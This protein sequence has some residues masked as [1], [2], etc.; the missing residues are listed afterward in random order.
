MRS[1]VSVTFRG[2]FSR[3]LKLKNLLTER[4]WSWCMSER[5]FEIEQMKVGGWINKQKDVKC[6][7]GHKEEENIINE[8]H[9]LFSKVI[10]CLH[11]L[12][13]RSITY[14]DKF[15]RP[16]LYKKHKFLLTCCSCASQAE[17]PY[18]TDMFKSVPVTLKL[19]A[20]INSLELRI[21]A[22]KQTKKLGCRCRLG[23][24]FSSTK[25]KKACTY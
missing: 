1:K 23:F 20:P 22:K 15:T 12:Y 18:K 10:Y 13:I 8:L 24:S 3:K 6:W 7:C 25:I 14:F 4:S 16:H 2:C 21:R 17:A 5:M 11:I 19:Q 9:F